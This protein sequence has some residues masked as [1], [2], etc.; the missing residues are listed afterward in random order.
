MLRFL[1]RLSSLR[2][3]GSTTSSTEEDDDAPT[4]DSWTCLPASLLTS[5]Y[6]VIGEQKKLGEII[7]L[8]RRRFRIAGTGKKTKPQRIHAPPAKSNSTTDHRMCPVSKP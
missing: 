2:L 5:E 1:Q 6:I 7:P 8:L 3:T 4:L